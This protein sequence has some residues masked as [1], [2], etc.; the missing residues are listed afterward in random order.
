MLVLS[1]MCFG[2]SI[3]TDLFCIPNHTCN[4][5][6]YSRGNG[7]LLVWNQEGGERAGNLYGVVGLAVDKA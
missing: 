5:K 7:Q 6:L 2:S 1:L 4:H 3:Y